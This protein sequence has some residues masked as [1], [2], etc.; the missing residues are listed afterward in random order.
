M[1]DIELKID[2]KDYTDTLNGMT[3]TEIKEYSK[4]IASTL[5]DQTTKQNRALFAIGEKCTTVDWFNEHMQTVE[6]DNKLLVFYSKDKYSSATGEFIASVDM[7]K[8]NVKPNAHTFANV[9]KA[10]GFMTASDITTVTDVQELIGIINQ[11]E[12]QINSI[13]DGSD[14]LKPI[15][16]AYRA[17]QR[18][19]KTI[20]LDDRCIATKK[21]ALEIAKLGIR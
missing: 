1:S 18:D 12:Q 10:K 16:N 14:E 5:K 17:H 20:A 8:Y 4:R 9:L 7:V 21:T 2:I 19:V 15:V 3:S 13:M 6:L 11:H